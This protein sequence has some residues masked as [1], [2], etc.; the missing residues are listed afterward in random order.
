MS[1]NKHL[2]L[3]PE[4]LN[5]VT[6][7]PLKT[8]NF[9]D[10]TSNTHSESSI[11]SPDSKSKLKVN[12]AEKVLFDEISVHEVISSPIP[13]YRA[14][15]GRNKNTMF[16]PKCQPIEEFDLNREVFITPEQEDI[17]NKQLEQ[18]VDKVKASFDC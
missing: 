11:K 15:S 13:I 17:W 6:V 16:Y 9:T 18:M 5:K 1:P 8:E 14:M 12:V 7:K 10:R 3:N 4:A 2:H